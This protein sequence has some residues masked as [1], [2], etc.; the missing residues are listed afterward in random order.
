MLKSD[1]KIKF[2]SN[3]LKNTLNKAITKST[4]NIKCP[5]CQYNLTLSGS[6]FGSSIICPNCKTTIVINDDGLKKD[7][8]KIKL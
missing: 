4:F 8:D 1:V 2:N 7:I 6:Q 5:K 3:A